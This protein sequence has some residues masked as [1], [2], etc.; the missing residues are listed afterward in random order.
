MQMTCPCC[1]RTINTYPS[2]L[3][4]SALTRNFINDALED[5]F[6]N[7]CFNP[8]QRYNDTRI[9]EDL[10][11]EREAPELDIKEAR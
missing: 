8:D 7:D 10:E 9:V 1:S 6:F 2:P 3:N 4:L 11:T 5:K